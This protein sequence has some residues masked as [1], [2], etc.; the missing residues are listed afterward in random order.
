MMTRYIQDLSGSDSFLSPFSNHSIVGEGGHTFKTAY[1]YYF[2]AKFGTTATAWSNDAMAIS[3]ISKIVVMSNSRRHPILPKWDERRYDAMRRAILLKLRQHHYLVP[4]L[5]DTGGDPLTYN[6]HP[7]MSYWGGGG[8]GCKNMLG[9]LLSELRKEFTTTVSQIVDSIVDADERQTLSA[10]T[11]ADNSTDTTQVS[12]D[13]EEI[14]SQTLLDDYF[15]ETVQLEMSD[16]RLDK[17]VLPHYNIFF[18][19][20]KIAPVDTNLT[21]PFSAF[22][23]VSSTEVDDAAII[24]V[25][26]LLQKLRITHTVTLS[27]P[28]GWYDV[29]INMVAGALNGLPIAPVEGSTHWVFA[30]GVI[31]RYGISV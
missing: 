12:N 16:M 25:A 23:T 31:A 24:K 4:L 1:H 27:D 29:V 18:G 19:D 5:V 13:E 11:A 14:S 3:D 28:A 17:I 20:S 2:H 30:S 26:R 8:G 21:I 10:V 22:K 9:Q 6:V 15:R 7:S